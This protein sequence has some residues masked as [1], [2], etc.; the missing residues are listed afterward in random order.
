VDVNGSD[1]DPLFDY[2]K[3]EKKGLLNND[4]KWNCESPRR[5]VWGGRTGNK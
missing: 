4:I 2:L 1:A 3:S 5:V